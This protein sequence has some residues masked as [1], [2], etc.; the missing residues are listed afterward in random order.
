M[1]GKQLQVTVSYGDHMLSIMITYLREKIKY[2]CIYR[3][4]WLASKMFETKD[5]AS[6]DFDYCLVHYKNLSIFHIWFAKSMANILP[7][8]G[9]PNLWHDKF[10][11]QTN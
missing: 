6:H 9:L 10:W 7:N 5:L 4:D 3:P 2:D 8:F 11:G 1:H